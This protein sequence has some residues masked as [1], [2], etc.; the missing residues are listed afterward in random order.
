[1]LLATPYVNTYLER[2]TRFLLAK[3]Y[4]PTWTQKHPSAEG[5]RMVLSPVLEKVQKISFSLTCI[6]PDY[7]AHEITKEF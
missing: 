7:L 3:I 1:M 2:C 6:L 4:K 5:R